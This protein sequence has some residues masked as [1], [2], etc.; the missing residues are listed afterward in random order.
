M[1]AEQ[2]K[3]EGFSDSAIAIMVEIDKDYQPLA[4]HYQPYLG[5]FEFTQEDLIANYELVVL[6]LKNHR[7]FFLLFQ[8][9]CY[10]L[11]DFKN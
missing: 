10:Y 11:T 5:N 1:K 6:W 7:E 9:E 2:L 8:H 4:K 3:K